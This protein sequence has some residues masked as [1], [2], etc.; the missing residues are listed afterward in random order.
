[1]NPLPKK[2]T[3]RMLYGRGAD[4]R[5]PGDRR[6]EP[7]KHGGTGSWVLVLGFFFSKWFSRPPWLDFFFSSL[8]WRSGFQQAFSSGRVNSLTTPPKGSLIARL[9]FFQVTFW[10]V[11]LFK[12]RFVFCC[13]EAVSSH[14]SLQRPFPF[15]FLLVQGDPVARAGLFSSLHL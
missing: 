15:V 8:I 7:S 6:K 9:R 1:M 13:S 10:A 2:V 3:R 5:N 14:F 12:K 4:L 11:G